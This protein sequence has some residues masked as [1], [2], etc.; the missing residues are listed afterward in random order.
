MAKIPIDQLIDIV[1]GELTFSG[2]MPKILPDKEIKRLIME[3]CLEYFYKNYQFSTIKIALHLKDYFL[4]TYEVHS[5]HLLANRYTYFTFMIGNHL[6]SIPFYD[7][8]RI[9]HR[10]AILT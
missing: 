1:Q 5:S 6:C 2:A 9:I 10:E 7:R 4:E 8:S 3:R